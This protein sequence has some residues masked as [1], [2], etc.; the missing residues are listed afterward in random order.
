MSSREI[1]GLILR[2]CGLVAVYRGF[3]SLL[4]S[5][6]FMFGSGH[7]VQGGWQL[8]VFAIMTAGGIYLL[9]G[10]PSLMRFCYP[11]NAH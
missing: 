8:I 9:R 4:V 3:A 10:A 11:P 7:M 2:V 6:S 1:F 5:A